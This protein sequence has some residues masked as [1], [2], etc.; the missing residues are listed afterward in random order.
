MT[1]WTRAAFM[2]FAALALAGCSRKGGK[3]EDY[4]P[5]PDQARKALEAA[6]TS[7]KN[8]DA[9]GTVPGTKNPRVDVMDSAWQTGQKLAG[10]EILRE[11]SAGQGPRVFVVRLTPSG[12]TPQEVRYCVIGIDP[13]IVAREEDYNKMSGTGS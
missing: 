12:G 10:F 7:W 2:L 4:T 13:M 6:L 1:N 11:E 9:A 5:K 3:V 8:G